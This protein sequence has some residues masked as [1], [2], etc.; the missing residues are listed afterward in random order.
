MLIAGFGRV[1]QVPARLLRIL[2]IDFTAFELDAEQVQ[3]IRRFGN[4]V[5]YGDASRLDLLHAAGA[6]DAKFF[7]LAIDD[8]ESSLRTAE[9]VRENFPHLRIFARARN[10]AHVFKLMDLGITDIWRETFTSALE[11]SEELLQALGHSKEQT[12]SM[13]KTF[14][15]A[16]EKVIQEQ[17]KVRDNEKELINQTKLANE[18]L[19]EVLRRDLSQK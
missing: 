19:T 5:Y 3:L 11:M 4:K 7:I 14:R 10:R 15:E 2:K 12:Q 13:L 8:V 17:Y 1:G 18:Q 16:D 9:V 6:A